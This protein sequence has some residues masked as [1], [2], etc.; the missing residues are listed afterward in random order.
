MRACRHRHPGALLG[1]GVFKET[2]ENLRRDIARQKI[3][4]NFRIRRLVLI[5]HGRVAIR[6]LALMLEN[7]RD[8]LL[9]LRLLLNDR[10]ELAVEQRRDVET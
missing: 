10:D 1:R 5:G 7:G 8:Q 4:Q 2:L 6:L 3:G 9:G